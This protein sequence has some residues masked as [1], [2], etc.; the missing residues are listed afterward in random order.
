MRVW[1][2][3]LSSV[4][5]GAVERVVE[6]STVKRKETETEGEGRQG[7]QLS[8]PRPVWA[9]PPD[10]ATTTRRQRDKQAPA[11]RTSYVTTDLHLWHLPVGTLAVGDWHL[12]SASL[13]WRA[14]VRLMAGY[15][16]TKYRVSSTS[17][18][19][20][21]RSFGLILLSLSGPSCST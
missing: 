18:F 14:R 7:V 20:P 12:T 3:E 4:K 16:Y 6:L 19:F 5:D 10:N 1:K 17:I 2:Y 21:L 13:A 8:N 15:W 11:P 9:D